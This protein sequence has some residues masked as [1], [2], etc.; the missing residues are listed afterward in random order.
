MHTCRE[1]EN[2]KHS[3]CYACIVVVKDTPR[4]R[5]ARYPFTKAPLR[6]AGRDTV[7]SG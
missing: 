2:E 1:K 4:L 6:R 3:K 5:A 7:A